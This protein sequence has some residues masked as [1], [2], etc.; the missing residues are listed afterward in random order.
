MAVVKVT[1]NSQCCGNSLQNVNEKEY[2]CR[3]GMGTP[4]TFNYLNS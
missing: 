1:A 2:Y 3:K 4:V